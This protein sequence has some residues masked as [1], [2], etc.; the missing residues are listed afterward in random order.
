MERWR[1]RGGARV[2]FSGGIA[3]RKYFADGNGGNCGDVR[4]AICDRIVARRQQR[5]SQQFQ[6]GINAKAR[7]KRA[8]RS[9]W[10]QVKSGHRE[11][12]ANTARTLRVLRAGRWPLQRQFKIK[13][14][15]KF[16]TA[17]QTARSSCATL[18]R[19]G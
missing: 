15:D 12:R 17:S 16:K 1:D 10:R 3:R 2:R 5:V 8:N 9:P 7:Y 13:R 6:T 11:T 19:R 4:D 14:K 18:T